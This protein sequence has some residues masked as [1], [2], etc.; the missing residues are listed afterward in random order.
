[1]PRAFGP[2]RDCREVLPDSEWDYEEKEG[3]GTTFIGSLH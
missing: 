3:F 1:M 2:L